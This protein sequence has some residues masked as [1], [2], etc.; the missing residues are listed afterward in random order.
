MGEIKVELKRDNGTGRRSYTANNVIAALMEH[1]IGYLFMLH[2]NGE[3]TIQSMDEISNLITSDI[4]I[5][6]A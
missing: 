1:D 4:E 2:S 3:E 5:Q 6:H